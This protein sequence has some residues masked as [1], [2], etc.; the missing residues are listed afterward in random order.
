[1]KKNLK[2]ASIFVLLCISILSSTIAGT[3]AYITAS[4]QEVWLPFS[5]STNE[6]PSMEIFRSNDT[7]GYELT[8]KVNITEIT[9]GTLNFQYESGDTLPSRIF[10]SSGIHSFNVTTMSA[11]LRVY[12]INASVIGFFS[13]GIGNR[14]SLSPWTDMN[15]LIILVLLFA[16]LMSS[17]GITPLISFLV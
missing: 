3:N 9:N 10:D 15:L 8:F 1:M 13:L 4:N 12:G 6:N 17:L 11:S 7:Y 14:V 16:L 5:L 2:F